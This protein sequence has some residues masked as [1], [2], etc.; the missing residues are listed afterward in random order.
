MQRALIVFLACVG[1]LSAGEVLMVAHKW[2]DSLGFYDT[3]SGKSLKTIPVGIKPHEFALTPD[4]KLAYVTNYGVDR[5]TEKSQGANTISI[6]D[7]ERREKIG[8][9]NLGRFHRPHG[10]ERGASG[11]LYITCDLP[12]SLVVV[13]PRK[14]AVVE[15]YD[16]GQSLPHMV[17]VTHDEKK[18]YTANSGS[19]TVTAI[20][21]GKPKPVAHIAIGGVP[22]GLAMAADGSRLYAANRTG[23]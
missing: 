7:L 22:M 9:I 6:V 17:A 20:R 12:P 18:A 8:E 14:K 1:G 15:H 23:H 19:A 11:R 13:D 21:M 16:V 4:R 10:I 2:A 5:Y 3:T